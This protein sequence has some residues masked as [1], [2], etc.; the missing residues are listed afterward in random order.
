M[1]TVDFGLDGAGISSTELFFNHMI[2]NY[3]GVKATRKENTQSILQRMNNWPA[4]N[5]Q[6]SIQNER[7]PSSLTEALD[8]IIV[9]R[10]PLPPHRLKPSS[11]VNVDHGGNF[12]THFR[13]ETKRS[14]HIGRRLIVLEE[15]RPIFVQNRWSKRPKP[16]SELY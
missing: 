15:L 12:F 1:S 5:V 13:T 10:I 8:K 11:S 2:L 7:N 14:L 4:H 6:T 9:S 16:F 3:Q